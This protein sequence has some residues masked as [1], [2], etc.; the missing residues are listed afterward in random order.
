MTTGARASPAPCFRTPRRPSSTLHWNIVTLCVRHGA[1]LHKSHMGF[2]GIRYP[3][4]ISLKD[5]IGSPI[6]EASGHLGFPA[7]IETLPDGTVFTTGDRLKEYAAEYQRQ[8]GRKPPVNMQN[9]LFSYDW[10]GIL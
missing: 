5:V 2:L 4:A 3:L 7:F 6:P 8:F 1:M 9:S 10:V